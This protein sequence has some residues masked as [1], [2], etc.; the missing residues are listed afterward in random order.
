VLQ[1]TVV[2]QA[3][4]GV[5]SQETYDKSQAYSRAKVP[6]LDKPAK[7]QARYGFLNR[8]WS[9]MLNLFILQYNLMPWFWNLTGQWQATYLGAKFQGEVLLP[10]TS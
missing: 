10:P 1:H 4:K 7:F 6:I 2:P 3:L 9:Q 8:A 5:L